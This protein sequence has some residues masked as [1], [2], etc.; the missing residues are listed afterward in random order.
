MSLELSNASGEIVSDA[1]VDLADHV[2]VT[3]QDDGRRVFVTDST[4]LLDDDVLELIP[5]IL[6]L[7]LS[8]EVSEIVGRVLLLSRATMSPAQLF[9]EIHNFA[10]LNVLK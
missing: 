2:Y 8:G 3:V 6:K 5:M 7:G 1:L 10:R 9:K 4:R